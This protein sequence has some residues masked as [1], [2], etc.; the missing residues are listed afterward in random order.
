MNDDRKFWPFP[1]LPHEQQTASHRRHIEFLVAA[2]REGFSPFADL[3]NFGAT[4][5]GGGRGGWLIYRGHGRGRAERWELNVGSDGGAGFS[6]LF[7]P[8]DV[9]ADA[10]LRW[11]RGEDEA[12][13]RDFI[14]PH[15]EPPHVPTDR[16]AARK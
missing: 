4:A 6:V 5:A 1:T 9:A 12:S 13:I 3:S 16:A 7:L 10:L 2:H 15:R 14:A 8:F 11:L